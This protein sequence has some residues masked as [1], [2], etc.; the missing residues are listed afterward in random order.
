MAKTLC[1]WRRNDIATDLKGL[2]KLVKKPTFVCLK[3]ARVA[4]EKK[5][6]CSGSKLK[7]E[8]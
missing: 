1:K 6:L 3:C 8:A 4:N 2:R 5:V 7:K